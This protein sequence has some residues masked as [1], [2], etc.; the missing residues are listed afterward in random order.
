MCIANV[1]HLWDKKPFLAGGGGGALAPLLWISDGFFKVYVISSL[2]VLFSHLHLMK[3]S[4]T[5]LGLELVTSY[6]LGENS[7]A[8]M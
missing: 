3:S 5:W 1:A 7:V 6:M 4:L 8:A 2:L